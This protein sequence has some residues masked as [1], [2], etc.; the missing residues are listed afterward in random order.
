MEKKGL[1]FAYSTKELT[2]KF[3]DETRTDRNIARVNLK[4][5]LNAKF[6]GE[7]RTPTESLCKIIK[8]IQNN[9]L[10]FGYLAL[11]I[12]DDHPLLKGWTGN[13]RRLDLHF[14]L[15]KEILSF[16]ND[17]VALELDIPRYGN[18]QTKENIEKEMV[19]YKNFQ[20]KLLEKAT[21]SSKNTKK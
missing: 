4:S 13:Y 5:V 8:T 15:G 18:T 14:I 1:P 17:I 20:K 16:K 9:E 21:P 12:S 19:P 3:L 10:D 6:L 7:S 2:N 11:M